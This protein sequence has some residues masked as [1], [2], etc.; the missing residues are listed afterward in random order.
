MAR[1]PLPESLHENL[2]CDSEGY[3]ARL[4]LHPH[5]RGTESPVI[6]VHQRM[7]AYQSGELGTDDQVHATVG[8]RLED[9]RTSA[10]CLAVMAQEDVTGKMK[11][12]APPCWALAGTLQVQVPLDGPRPACRHVGVPRVVAVP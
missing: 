2:W 6:E 11:P 1:M 9:S 7:R 3:Q 10:Y 8:L 4:V 5:Q 12:P